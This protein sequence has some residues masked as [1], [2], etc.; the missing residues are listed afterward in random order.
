MYLLDTDVCIYLLNGRAT[1]IER[2]LREVPRSMVGT[3]AITI[4]ELYYGALHSARPKKNQERVKA[5]L[6]PLQRIP[7]GDEAAQQFGRIKQILSSKG[8]L[9]GPMDLLIAATAISIG[10]RFVTNNLSEFK[11]VPSLQIANWKID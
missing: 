8:N 1:G 7:F 4:A 3:S 11:R 9:I 10:A 2:R 5:F 6:E